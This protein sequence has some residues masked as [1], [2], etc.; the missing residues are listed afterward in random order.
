MKIEGTSQ[1]PRDR[2]LWIL[3]NSG[4][5]LER[6]RLRRCASTRYADLEHIIEELVQLGLNK[7]IFKR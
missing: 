4:G 7:P 2:I 1:S 6:T 5:K 3:A